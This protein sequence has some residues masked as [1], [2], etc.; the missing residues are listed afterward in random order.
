[1]KRRL[2]I[3]IALV[4]LAAAAVGTV[5]Y[6]LSHTEEPEAEIFPVDHLREEFLSV[7]VEN[8]K[9]GFSFR[10]DPESSLGYYCEH[11]EG[12]PQLRSSYVDVVDD[13]VNI[14]AAYKYDDSD[15]SRYGLKDPAVKAV[16]T[17]KDGT[18]YTVC[19]GDDAPS[20]NY[21]YYSVSDYPGTV[22]V[23]RK[24]QFLN[25]RQDTF[26]FVNRLLA[27][28][29]ES[30]SSGNY[31]TDIADRLTFT[32]RN[33][34]VVSLT[35]YEDGYED[36]AGQRY[37]Y[38]Q[39]SP[40][41]GNVTGAAAQAHLARIMQ[42]CASNVIKKH[43]TEEDI[44]FYG[45]DDPFTTVTIG[46]KDEDATVRL[47]PAP[48]G[49]FYAYKEGVNVIWLVADYLV[50]WMDIGPRTLLSEYL[51]APRIEDVSSL[52]AACYGKEYLFKIEGDAVSLDGSAVDG[53][54]F[55]KLYKL[56]C[57]VN[58]VNATSEKG[59]DAVISLT[60]TQKDGKARK[61]ELIDLGNRNLSIRV[62][63]ADMGLQIRESYAET[64]AEACEAVK[65]GK[66][67]SD[68]W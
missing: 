21:C 3:L 33:G 22:F 2:T 41:E 16:V 36:G 40:V 37:R 60:F 1:M 42:F 28:K 4:L 17:L 55:T 46:Y 61:L 43:P 13:L 57:S 66:E 24:S 15:Y 45:L 31:E 51:L 67:F 25:Y 8:E 63:G 68:L 5:W 19:V 30:P 27:P 56:A 62:D 53:G 6:I 10:A 26:Y 11:L 49:N 52:K 59:G 47:S 35:I 39:S 38:F 44:A 9:G 34:E 7:T 50:T 65:E 18:E 48:D 32:N 20:E 12:L 54:L 29:T 14:K 64:L 23:I 58:S